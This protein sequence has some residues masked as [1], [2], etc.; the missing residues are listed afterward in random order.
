MKP[1][2]VQ[3]RSKPTAVLAFILPEIQ[4]NPAFW[5]K[6][7]CKTCNGTGWIHYHTRVHT[8]VSAEHGVRRKMM[9]N[10]S[11]PCGCSTKRFNR[12]KAEGKVYKLRLKWDEAIW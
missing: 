11:A 7:N 9:P 1:A 12:A 8:T 4:R 6:P 5:A 3:Q 2:L 10:E